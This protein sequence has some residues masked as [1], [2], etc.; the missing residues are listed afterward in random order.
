MSPS[1]PQTYL[2]SIPIQYSQIPKEFPAS[3]IKEGYSHL[4]FG[5]VRLAL[6][7]HGRK[8]LP[9]AAKIALLDSRF[10]NYQ[11]A[12]VGMMQ[13]TLNAGTSVHSRTQAAFKRATAPADARKWLTAYERLQKPPPVITRTDP[14]FRRLQ[15][16][17]VEVS[18]PKPKPDESSSSSKIFST[19][20]AEINMI[21]F[22]PMT[23][24]NLP[25][26]Y[27]TKDGGPVYQGKLD[28]REVRLALIPRLR[29]SLLEGMSRSELEGRLED[30]RMGKPEGKHKRG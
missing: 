28:N 2:F 13:T 10:I 16:D 19:T 25:A 1:L 23:R 6:T 22:A 24:E 20:M 3:W 17:Q 26:K 9:V 11:H 5:A 8:G 29:E 12:C 15:G 7:F 14:Q 4:H 27:F 18:F 30:D 21:S